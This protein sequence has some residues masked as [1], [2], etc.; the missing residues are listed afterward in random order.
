MAT[1]S[2]TPLQVEVLAALAGLEPQWRLSGG[3]ALV[4]FHGARRTTRD[5]DLFWTAPELGRVDE[6]VRRRLAAAG[7]RVVQLQRSPAFCRLRV[8]KDGAVVLLDLVAE[9]MPTLEAPGAHAVE[10]TRILVD[11]PHELL[12][13]K[14][15]ALLGRSE[16]R[17]LADVRSLL[18]EGGD[19]PR[20]VADAP[21]KDAGFSPVTL[22]WVLEQLPV[23]AMAS[24]LG[25]PQEE[26]RVLEAFRAELVS[27]VLALARP[28]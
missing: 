28:E 4:G 14:L 16:L 7:A 27:A 23:A 20:A 10:G 5:L 25:R 8:E 17:D 9:P 1:G 22:A 18:A 6:E 3:A 21:R 19:L 2:L 13:S 12:V 11:G 15:C 26:A 24:A